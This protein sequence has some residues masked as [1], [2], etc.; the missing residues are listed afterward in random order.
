[1]CVFDTTAC[2][3][4]R[5]ER[6]DACEWPFNEIW[7]EISKSFCSYESIS[8][9]CPELTPLMFDW[10]LLTAL[11]AAWASSP[12]LV[13]LLLDVWFDVFIEWCIRW[14]VYLEL[15]IIIETL[16]K[17]VYFDFFRLLWLLLAQEALFYSNISTIM[18][19]LYILLSKL[20]AG[21]K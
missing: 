12:L 6:T 11:D 15:S 17:S 18:V 1:M 7:S 8:F 19:W 10:L 4:L 5:L 9:D 13:L 3:I 21:L 16:T 2:S 20:I 14:N